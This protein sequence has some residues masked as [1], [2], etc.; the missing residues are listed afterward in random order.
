MSKNKNIPSKGNQKIQQ[1]FLPDLKP[2]YS[3]FPFPNHILAYIVLGLVSCVIYFNS[4]WNENALDDGII[5][6]KNEF[7]LKGTS[8][9]KDIMTRDSYYSFYRQMNA[10]DQ[11]KGG[12]YRPLSVVTFALEQEYI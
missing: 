5:I 1:N 2:N 3:L 12:R 10:Q 6:Q 4:I 7:V 8:G 11:L 9:I